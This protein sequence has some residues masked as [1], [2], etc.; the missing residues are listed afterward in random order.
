MYKIGDNV[1][2]GANGVMTVL[3]VREETIGDSAR[4]YYVLGSSSGRQD[5]LTFVPT[6]NE[7][8]VKCIR[9]LMSAA[10][11]EAL[12]AD[13][14]V[15]PEHQWIADNR[16]RAESFRSVVESADPRAIIGV[17]KAIQ[18]T[19]ERRNAEGKKNYLSDEG[20]M[21]K[22]EYV[23]HSELSAVLGIDPTEVEEYIRKRVKEI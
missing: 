6:D 8:L 22:A 21:R 23:L 19:G 14:P 1:V 7:A 16:R 15:I 13:I 12:I 17:M 20:V 9:P 4:T 2:Y 10:E 18:A 3:D 5:S 11:V